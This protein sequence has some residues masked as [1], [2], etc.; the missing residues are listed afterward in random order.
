MLL[1]NLHETGLMEIIDISKENLETLESKNDVT[2]SELDT[3]TS[4]NDRLSKLINILT[5]VKPKKKGIKAILHPDLPEI[6]I[7]EDKTLDELYSYAEGFLDK[8]EKNILE[9][10]Q[11]LH[12]LDEEIKKINLN[13]QQ[14]NYIK[15]FNVDVSDIGESKYLVIKAG[16]TKD[17]ESIRTQVEGL[18]KSII[19]SK[20]FGTGKKVE[21]A[22]IS[23][24]LYI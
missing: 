10:E 4:Y 21:W 6:K 2:N 15:D 8:I 17:I 18:E 13:I 23:G 16:K 9:D 20:Q 14:L 12:R 5:K 22:V 7:V 19:Y 11:K 1:K 24:Y 3:C